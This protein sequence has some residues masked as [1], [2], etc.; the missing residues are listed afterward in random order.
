MKANNSEILNA[1]ADLRGLNAWGLRR[2]H[3]SMFFLEIGKP[4]LRP[5]EK[6]KHGEWHF[7]F[8]MCDWKITQRPGSNPF[9][10][11][12]SSHK[13]IDC[14]F[15]EISENLG[16]IVAVRL[17]T[18]QAGIEVRLSSGVTIKTSPTKASPTDRWTQW[19]LFGPHDHA[20][21]VN[22]RGRVLYENIYQS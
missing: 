11:S 22:E 21:V 9:L 4:V 13:L 2:T 12:A 1:F 20:W 8:E 6:K 15:S 14:R 17:R 10:T 18:A 5:G 3:G 16:Q 19:Q 7:L